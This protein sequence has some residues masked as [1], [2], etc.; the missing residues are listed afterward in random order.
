[1]WWVGGWGEVG[2][3]RSSHRLKQGPLSSGRRGWPP[4]HPPA[5]T[6]RSRCKASLLLSTP[7][8]AP[9]APARA[10]THTH[11]PGVAPGLAGLRLC[12]QLQ[13][14]VVQLLLQ[15]L[16]RAAHGLRARLARTGRRVQRSVA[17]ASLH[18]RGKLGNAALEGGLLS[19]LLPARRV[20]Q[21]WGTV[22]QWARV[23]GSE[24]VM[25]G[26]V[27]W[28]VGHLGG[29]RRSHTLLRLRLGRQQLRLGPGRR[30]LKRWAAAEQ[31]ARRTWGRC[32]WAR[33]CGARTWPPQPEGPS[34]A[35]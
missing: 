12:V 29:R 8:A 28:L 26:L 4:A 23:S 14:Q 5:S 9:P 31:R 25:G 30:Q 17:L 20:V 35:P 24:W 19:C 1:M 15:R 16:N 22:R 34:P 10:R 2:G 6:P 13:G 3:R 18:A 27:S 7:P 33:A 21:K 11:A 32:A